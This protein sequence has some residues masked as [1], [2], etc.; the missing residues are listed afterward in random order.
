MRDTAA[1]CLLGRVGFCAVYHGIWRLTAFYDFWI[2]IMELVLGGATLVQH[3]AKMVSK[4]TLVANFVG[5]FGG[6]KAVSWDFWAS[7]GLI[8]ASILGAKMTKNDKQ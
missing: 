5:H 2:L 1:P 8:L 6:P 4:C 7:I 3:S